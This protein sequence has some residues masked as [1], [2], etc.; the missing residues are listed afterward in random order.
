MRS[1]QPGPQS[2]ASQSLGVNSA[3]LLDPAAHPHCGTW[4]MSAPG[5]R[6]TSGL[7]WRSERDTGG[8]SRVRDTVVAMSGR[9][10]MTAMNMSTSGN[11]R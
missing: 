10:T 9:I 2:K 7:A 3:W 11:P 4:Y 1:H 6:K 8:L 5:N